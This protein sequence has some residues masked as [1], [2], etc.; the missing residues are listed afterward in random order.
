MCEREVNRVEG[1]I[2]TQI[3]AIEPQIDAI[4]S[5]IDAIESQIDTDRRL[6]AHSC[7]TRLS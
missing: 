2:E 5:Q 1:A 6:V 4:Q 7:S 3:D